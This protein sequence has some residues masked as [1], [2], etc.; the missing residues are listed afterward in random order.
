MVRV[1]EPGQRHPYRRPGTG[2]VPA[3]LDGTALRPDG[4]HFDGA[5]APKVAAW[6]APTL[7]EEI[8]KTR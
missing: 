5:S 8:A 1:D 6:L 4:V 2:D 3:T 7:T